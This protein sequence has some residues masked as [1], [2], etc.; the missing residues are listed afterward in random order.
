M[1]AIY[2]ISKNDQLSESLSG[3]INGHFGE[4]LSDDWLLF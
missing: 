1:K 4:T 3:Q 2:L